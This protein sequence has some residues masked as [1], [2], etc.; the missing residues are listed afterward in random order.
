M[1]H[2]TQKKSLYSSTRDF[3]K[4]K[5][6]EFKSEVKAKSKNKVKRFVNWLLPL[7]QFGT[8]VQVYYNGDSTH[9]SYFGLALTIVYSVFLAY[10]LG[11]S[12]KKAYNWENPSITT[13]SSFLNVDDNKLQF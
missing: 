12:I 3:A 4:M 5:I 8:P 2:V 9:K 13:T 1:K 10:Y 7:D 11:S 6:S